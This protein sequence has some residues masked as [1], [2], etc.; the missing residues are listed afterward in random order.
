MQNNKCKNTSNVAI[1]K[2]K[3]SHNVSKCIWNQESKER[4]H[5]F[6]SESVDSDEDLW[7]RLEPPRR[8]IILGEI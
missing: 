6:K 3:T 4:D 1:C 2:G 5:S 7:P 8:F